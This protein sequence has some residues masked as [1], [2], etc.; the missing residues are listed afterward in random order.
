MTATAYERRKERERER[1]ALMS[2]KDRNITKI[3]DVE[4]PGRRAR[5]RKSLRLFCET[6]NPVS[7]S[8]PWCDDHLR[9][10]ERIEEAATRG[11]LY[12]F[13]MPRG[14]GKTTICRM[15]ALWV[16]SY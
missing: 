15:A 4:S 13:A 10:I 16:V 1:Q 3:P 9:A 14:T 12:A 11:A 2:Q 5:C 7:F 8:K 6:Y